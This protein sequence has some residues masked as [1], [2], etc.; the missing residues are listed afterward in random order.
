VSGVAQQGDAH[1][2][3]RLACA[4]LLL[5]P[6]RWASRASPNCSF[7]GTQL[8]SPA[9]SRSKLIETREQLRQTVEAIRSAGQ[10]IAFTNGCYDLLHVGHVRSLEG[11]R[12][13]GDRLIVGVN[14]DASVRRNKGA[15]LPIVPEA[16]RAE[17]IGALAC[18][19]HVFVFDDPTTDGLLELIRPDAYCKG[20]EYTIE[21]LPERDTV[22]RLGIAFRQVGDPK[23]HST[24]ELIRRIVSA[25]GHQS[26]Q[27]RTREE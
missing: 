20:T 27:V 26:A 16:E 15:N 8:P 21:N 3:Q 17:V 13:W 6:G 19:D 22:K 5:R 14:S 25:H 24:T 11:A 2:K 23:D 12:R 18:V 1:A 9:V 7:G 4:V 10:T